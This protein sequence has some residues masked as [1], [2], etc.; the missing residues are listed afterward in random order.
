MMVH[1]RSR[2]LVKSVCIGVHLERYYRTHE[3]IKSNLE[4]I[5]FVEILMLLLRPLLGRTHCGALLTVK[6]IGKG[7]INESQEFALKKEFFSVNKITS[8]MSLISEGFATNNMK[9][10]KEI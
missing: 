4:I 9:P 8:I 7:V 1:N 5:S 10:N 6:V 3:T 2:D